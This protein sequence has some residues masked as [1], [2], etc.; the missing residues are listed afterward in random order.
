M[1][2][3]YIHAN[4]TIL[5]YVYPMSPLWTMT[6][7]F[8]FK[9]V[10]VMTM[11]YILLNWQSIN[12]MHTNLQWYMYVFFVLAYGSG[13]MCLFNVIS[14][15]FFVCVYYKPKTDTTLSQLRW[16]MIVCSVD[17]GEMVYH[18]CLSFFFHTIKLLKKINFE[19]WIYC[20]FECV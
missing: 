2:P 4:L 6:F 10:L 3:S 16:E 9:F 15:Y 18:H 11:A 7:L 17:I 19:K 20:H 13:T 12:L 1:S 5:H 14:C 8:Y